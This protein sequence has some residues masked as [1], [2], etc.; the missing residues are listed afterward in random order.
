MQALSSEAQA[1]IR[2][3]TTKKKNVTPREVPEICGGAKESVFT[4]EWSLVVFDEAHALRTE[5]PLTHAAH[6]LR[7]KSSMVILVT[8]TPL[9]KSEMVRISFVGLNMRCDD[10]SV[11]Q[12]LVSLGSIMGVQRYEALV[13][14]SVD[15][16][17]QIK[18]MRKAANSREEEQSNR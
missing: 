8:A 6:A 5:G 16:K 10:L 3:K 14:A 13:D 11:L 1:R 15:L 12:D 17:A 9:H 4:K 18:N 2:F 7:T